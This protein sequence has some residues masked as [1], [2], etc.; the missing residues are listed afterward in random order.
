VCVCVSV[1]VRLAVLAARI[2]LA[3]LRLFSR[4]FKHL[5]MHTCASAGT[6]F[7]NLSR[8]GGDD[9]N[10]IDSECASNALSVIASAL[11]SQ[12]VQ[13]ARLLAS[14]ASDFMDSMESGMASLTRRLLI[15]SVLGEQARTVQ[16]DGSALTM[17][18][19]TLA[20]LLGTQMNVMAPSGSGI[21][22]TASFSV[23]LQLLAEAFGGDV[24]TEVDVQ[25][26]TH[27]HAP[28]GEQYAIVSPLFGLTLYAGNNGSEALISNL[29]TPFIIKI[30]VDT[31]SLTE[32]Q[33]MLFPQRARCAFW[34]DGEYRTDGCVVV[35]VTLDEVTCSCNHLTTFAVGVCVCMCFSFIC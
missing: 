11:I 33:Q 27:I 21:S 20:S 32:L 23:P 17:Q 30:P 2:F 18:K 14:E 26:Q 22:A 9:G 10:S 3:R 34:E 29:S 15:E 5:N 1:E 24:S 19:S 25:I 13:Y 31:S 35:A 28:G 6:L 7:S 12:R 16:V 8:S 4:F